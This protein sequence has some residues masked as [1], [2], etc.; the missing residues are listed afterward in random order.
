MVV[1]ALTSTG[2]GIS[3]PRPL[4]SSSAC[5]RVGVEGVGA[6]AV[7]RVGRQHDQLAALHGAGRGDAASRPSS[8]PVASR[9]RV[10]TV[11]PVV[12]R[13]GRRRPVGSSRRP[14]RRRRS[15]VAG[16]STGG[17]CPRGPSSSTASSCQPGRDEP[18]PAGQVAVVAHVGPPAGR[19]RTPRAP[20]RPARRRARRRP[21]P[22][23]A[24]GRAA[25]RSTTRIASRPSAPD[26]SARC[27]VVVAGL[28]GHRLPGLE[29][30]VRRVA[31]HHVDGAGQLG[32]RRRRG[33]RAA[34]RRR[35][36]RGCASAQRCGRLVDLDGVHP[37]VPAP[38]RPRPGRSRPSR[39]TRST[40]T[41]L[42]RAPPRLLDRPA[43]QHL[44]LGPRHEDARADHELDVA[45]PGASR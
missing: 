39:C 42:G 28:G 25:R 18:R 21:L 36:R 8:V 37:G 20:T 34:G 10:R 19:R 38:R 40:T 1:A 6:H 22:R 17:S 43:G 9:S 16:R 41:G 44:G 13:P 5:D 2:G 7:D 30:D 12:R 4:A 3:R 45:E 31:D 14:P 33:R 24:A 29:R 23:A 11:A 32:E 26:H 15:L 27:R 35:C